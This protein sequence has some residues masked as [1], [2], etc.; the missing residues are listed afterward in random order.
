VSSHAYPLSPGERL[1]LERFLELLYADSNRLNLTRVP[2]AEAWS[3][4]VE[5]SLDLLPLRDWTAGERV[6]DLGS[7][8]GIPGIP[9]A[10]ARPRLAI[11]LIERDRAK[12]AFLLSCLGALELGLVRVLARDARELARIQDF[13]P[14]DVLVSRAAQPLSEVLRAASR[15]LRPGGEGVVH[16]GAS[17]TI[18]G[19]VA[20]AAE[21]V[22]VGRLRLERSGR[23]RFVRF[24]RMGSG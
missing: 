7:G 14:A 6:I 17:A 24:I 18:G 4:H 5:E 16:V 23:S 3:R 9:L 1:S 21:R 22:G 11:E 12:A 20:Q 8:G 2:Q 13:Q 10:I 15:L 19:D